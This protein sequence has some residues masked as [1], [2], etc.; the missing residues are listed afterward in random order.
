MM[1]KDK[2]VEALYAALTP[3]IEAT[4]PDVAAIEADARFTRAVAA[5]WALRFQLARNAGV[6]A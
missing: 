1:M 3:Q 4:H 6:S 5:E 2:A